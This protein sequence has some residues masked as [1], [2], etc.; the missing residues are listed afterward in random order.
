MGRHTSRKKIIPIVGEQ[1]RLS[2]GPVRW[3]LL[4]NTIKQQLLEGTKII[5]EIRQEISQA[6]KVRSM[7]PVEVL[8][9]LW[10][11]PGEAGSIHGRATPLSVNGDNLLGVQLPAQ[12]AVHRERDV[13]RAILVHEF[14]HCFSYATKIWHAMEAG[15]TRVEIQKSPDLNEE[16]ADRALLI[17][18]ADWFGEQDA[19]TFAYTQDERLEAVDQELIPLKRHLQVVTPPLKFSVSGIGLTEDVIE[20]IKKLRDTGGQ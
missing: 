12:V 17:K 20:H 19:R 4:P 13:I 10:V 7:P 14:A 1:V 2:V 18:P 5:A 8:D 11:V 6:A 9:E 16:E 15:E 3:S